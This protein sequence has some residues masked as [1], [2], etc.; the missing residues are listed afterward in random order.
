M[1]MGLCEAERLTEQPKNVDTVMQK[2]ALQKSE[3]N[4]HLNIEFIEKKTQLKII[5]PSFIVRQKIVV[6]NQCFT[7]IK[8][9]SFFND[10]SQL[11]NL[12]HIRYFSHPLPLK[13]HRVVSASMCVGGDDVL[14]TPQTIDA[15]T[16]IVT[17]K[18]C[19]SSADK[20]GHNLHLQSHRPCRR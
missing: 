15:S 3:R 6:T 18:R 1:L 19:R 8:S 7:H 10:R 11:F 2:S 13:I 16:H 12:F 5:V 4:F 9:A 14:D 17:L 20:L